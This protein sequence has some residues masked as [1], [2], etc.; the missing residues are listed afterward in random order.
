LIDLFFEELYAEKRKQLEFQS[1][2]DVLAN[3][4]SQSI[5]TRN[6][7][8]T[9]ENTI[10]STNE[11][12][13][14]DLQIQ[15]H[16]T[17]LDQFTFE[18]MAS[19]PFHPLRFFQFP[20]ITITKL[21]SEDSFIDGKLKF[22]FE[23]G[24]AAEVQTLNEEEE[25][26]ELDEIRRIPEIDTANDQE[27]SIFVLEDDI[28]FIPYSINNNQVETTTAADTSS[29]SQLIAASHFYYEIHSENLFDYN[30]HLYTKNEEIMW[31]NELDLI[32]LLPKISIFQEANLE[33][34]LIEI[35]DPFLLQQIISLLIPTNLSKMIEARMIQRQRQEQDQM[36]FADSHPGHGQQPILRELSNE[37]KEEMN[38]I[39]PIKKGNS[40][41]QRY[42]TPPSNGNQKRKNVSRENSFSSTISGS[43][44]RSDAERR[45]K[46]QEDKE[47]EEEEDEYDDIFKEVA[48]EHGSAN[49]NEDESVNN[50]SE[51]G[52]EVH[53][54]ELDELQEEID[55]LQKIAQ[56]AQAVLLNSPIDKLEGRRSTISS[57]IALEGEDEKNHNPNPLSPGASSG[58]AYQSSIT[59]IISSLLLSKDYHGIVYQFF[60]LL[61]QFQERL[62]YSYLNQLEFYQEVITSF[63]PSYDNQYH[64][65]FS[66]KYLQKK[67]LESYYKRHYHIHHVQHTTQQPQQQE[68]QWSP[69][70]NNMSALFPQEIGSTLFSQMFYHGFQGKVES[71]DEAMSPARRNQLLAKVNK[72]PISS[73]QHHLQTGGKE[74][75]DHGD[76]ARDKEE[77]VFLEYSPHVL[78]SREKFL[79]DISQTV[80]R[81]FQQYLHHHG[82]FELPVPEDPQRAQHTPTFSRLP[83]LTPEQERILFQLLLLSENYLAIVK[84][85]ILFHKSFSLML[86]CIRLSNSANVMIHRNTMGFFSSNAKEDILEY[87]YYQKGKGRLLKNVDF[88]IIALNS[89]ST[90]LFSSTN[91]NDYEDDGN[92]QQQQQQPDE[93]PG[94]VVEGAGQEDGDL[95]SGHRSQRKLNDHEA[96]DPVDFDDE[97][98]EVDEANSYDDDDD[99]DDIEI[100]KVCN[101]RYFKDRHKPAAATPRRIG[102]YDNSV[103]RQSSHS[104]S[105]ANEENRTISTKGSRHS[106]LS[107]PASSASSNN[108]SHRNG[109]LLDPI[110]E[111]SKAARGP[112][113]TTRTAMMIEGEEQQEGEE[114]EE[115]DGLHDLNHIRMNDAIHIFYLTIKYFV[116]KLHS[117]HSREESFTSFEQRMM[118]DERD[119]LRPPGGAKEETAA[120]QTEEYS[121]RKEKILLE[122][123]EEIVL[124]RPLPIT[125]EQ[126][127]QFFEQL[128]E[129][130]AGRFAATIELVQTFL[131]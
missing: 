11:R 8:D 64:V 86:Y 102:N 34:H 54:F 6:P 67:Q 38:H 62:C 28:C 63:S 74:N 109:F 66:D 125:D 122:M 50:L 69:S 126:L 65:L 96:V 103:R 119:L 40:K 21:I 17:C 104:S 85:L 72:R 106:R 48:S 100:F 44:T 73:S 84:Y 26:Y 32:T 77:D 22:S 41:A 9:K 25:L 13:D 10:P 113:T 90:D 128:S 78:E 93:Q 35:I 47:E 97:T 108:T 131:R 20:E 116:M 79:Y 36:K 80:S 68:Q 111:Q 130:Y 88:Q 120:N 18:L 7:F 83:H 114:E 110:F 57:Q 107:R 112:S 3:N 99:D 101:I 123:I 42:S 71:L 46:Q 118:D 124:S 45:N 89:P 87:Y 12:K 33:N 23:S 59:S 31:W 15:S 61:L 29:N 75:V 60:F 127:A 105:V 49:E 53:P 39:S 14:R 70:M 55:P 52:Q 117:I 24:I 19:Q 98:G 58:S 30:H 4:V 43:S 94:L 76:A 16:F 129:E 115:D 92:Q 91:I 5:T 51:D 2:S 82:P 56:N 37:E 27:N 95:V 121:R 81:I 1:V